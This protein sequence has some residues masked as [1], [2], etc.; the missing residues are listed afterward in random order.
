ML[1]G[2][3]T[4][5]Y[6]PCDV[7]YHIACLRRE[8]ELLAGA[9]EQA[10]LAALVPACPGWRV[11]DLLKH[12]GYVHRWAAS[13]V[14]ERQ[15]GWVDRAS[16]Q[17]ILSGGPGD[18]ALAGWFRAGHA[19]LVRTLE[20]A[21]PDMTCWTFLD[22][23]SPLAF[24]ARRQAHETAIHRVD[25]QQAAAGGGAAGPPGAKVAAAAGSATAGAAGETV[26]AP[27]F[28]ADGVDELIMGFLGRDAKRGSWDGPAGTVGFHADDA[29]GA[30]AHWRVAAEPGH[31]AVAREDGPADCHVTGG[32]ADLY[33]LLWNRRG[34]S[35]L[36]VRGDAAKLAGLAEQ[37]AVTWR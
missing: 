31:L 21:D 28:A 15:A 17:E 6:G 19:A 8:G 30:T 36:D 13:Y 20:A 1:S 7:A 5:Q 26:F 27:R 14:R 24:W 4:A 3:D 23:P 12:L 22:A 9:A 16:E 25:A 33:L 35:G 11:R 29:T 37:A 2:M 18:E 34:A 32:A 10:G